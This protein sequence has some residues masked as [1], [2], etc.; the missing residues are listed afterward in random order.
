[1]FKPFFVHMFT[2]TKREHQKRRGVTFYVSPGFNGDCLTVRVAECSK[3]DAYC[4]RVGRELAMQHKGDEIPIRQL[5]KYVATFAPKVYGIQVAPANWD[6]LYK[7][8]V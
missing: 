7:Y 6:Y 2:H 1:M 8:V 3:K 4:K 5:P